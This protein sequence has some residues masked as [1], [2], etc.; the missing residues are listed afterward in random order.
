MTA[1]SVTSVWHPSSE[2]F[3]KINGL[4]VAFRTFGEPGKKGTVLCLHGG[5]GATSEYL[6]PLSDLA[7]FGYHVVLYDQMGCGKSE[8]PKS[9]TDLTIE[10]HVEEA[11]GVRKALKLGK[12]HLF[13][14][15]WGGWLAYEY[16]FK[17]QSNLKSLTVAG[18]P[19]SVPEYFEEAE[20]MR[21]ELPKKMRETLKKYESVGDFQHPEYMA[22]INDYYK[23]RECRLP[24]W[25]A[26][27]L[28]SVQQ[29][30][31]PVYQ[32]MWGPNEITCVG[33]LRYWD[34]R[35][36]LGLINV[37]TL[38]T[39]GRYDVV[40]VASAERV[41][42][43]IKGSQLV[44]LEKSGHLSMWDE[45]EKFVETYRVFLDKLS[46]KELT[47]VQDSERRSQ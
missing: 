39:N 25:P 45:R 17:Y 43:G 8:M 5:P 11:E 23:M 12:I 6:L 20:K 21:S 22:A 10:N 3:L 19:A 29:T 35:H 7:N 28:Y 24:E 38:V 14:S 15:S 37:P 36:K 46:H 41:H 33:A 31:G 32:T 18:S 44:I 4:R 34:V 42:R 40:S 2:G 30:E 9:K 47:S 26:E 16:T 13:G 27:V 1:M